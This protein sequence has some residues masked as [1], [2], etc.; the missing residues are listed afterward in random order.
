MFSSYYY[1][2]HLLNDI[3]SLFTQEKV[4]LTLNFLYVLLAIVQNVLKCRKHD[5]SAP[6]IQP[7][8]LTTT[9]LLLELLR[10]G[11]ITF[12]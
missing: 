3:V 6:S 12:R 7:R 9:E 10:G 2:F 5:L 11:H 4:T 8:V 1:D